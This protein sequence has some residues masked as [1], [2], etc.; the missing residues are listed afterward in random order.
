[1]EPAAGAGAYPVERGSDAG[2]V[3]RDDQLDRVAIEPRAAAGT[4]IVEED[5]RR[6]HSV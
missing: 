3:V 2:D 6:R 1:M 5:E 4:R